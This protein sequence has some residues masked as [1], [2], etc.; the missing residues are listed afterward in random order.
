MVRILQPV[1]HLV[2]FFIFV[3]S[4]NA[5]Q[6]ASQAA[7]RQAVLVA[8]KATLIPPSRPCTKGGELCVPG[9]L[10]TEGD[11]NQDVTGTRAGRLG[12]CKKNKQ[13]KNNP[14]LI[15]A[16]DKKTIKIP[17]SV[18]CR[19]C[20]W[21]ESKQ[22]CMHGSEPC[23]KCERRY[24]H[25]TCKDKGSN[26]LEDGHGKVKIWHIEPQIG[27]GVVLDAAVLPFT[28]GSSPWSTIQ[29][30]SLS[31][32]VC[33][34]GWSYLSWKVQA[35]RHSKR[36]WQEDPPMAI[37]PTFVVPFGWAKTV[38]V[39]QHGGDCVETC[40]STRSDKL[41]HDLFAN[42]VTPK[43]QSQKAVGTHLQLCQVYEV[44]HDK[45]IHEDSTFEFPS[46]GHRCSNFWRSPIDSAPRSL[47]DW[48]RSYGQ[49]VLE[50][51]EV[52]INFIWMGRGTE[53]AKATKTKSLD[54][55]TKQQANYMI[56]AFEGVKQMITK[57]TKDEK[58]FYFYEKGVQSMETELANSIYSRVTKVPV[59]THNAG[60][61]I[62][63]ALGVTSSAAKKAAS[64]LD[65]FIVDLYSLEKPPY[66]F[67]KDVIAPFVGFVNGGYYFDTNTLPIKAD[68]EPSKFHDALLENRR[69]WP[70][71]PLNPGQ[72][73]VNYPVS[74]VGPTEINMMYHP[75]GHE[76][77]LAIMEEFIALGVPDQNTPANELGEM[78]TDA[79]VTVQTKQFGIPISAMLWTPR[80]PASADGKKRCKT[81]N[82]ETGIEVFDAHHPI[83]IKCYGGTWRTAAAE[84]V[85]SK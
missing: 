54:I 76:M 82:S 64:K 17:H 79:M 45:S 28:V 46:L 35:K 60:T 62:L 16:S 65:P 80:F 44:N 74:G 32:K 7:F 6:T 69:P 38:E 59:N 49:K 68:L 58:I 63:N 11:G 23:A 14:R 13:Q 31:T 18:D 75:K 3:G 48:E 83:L 71:Y 77:T 43:E 5:V 39:Q 56:Q 40:L 67:V 55:A 26:T 50:T 9:F 12:K 72:T 53:P 4:T 81:L 47:S 22:M 21:T 15:S 78:V 8:D 19:E 27:N 24:S 36:L 73:L 66:A 33:V 51:T 85:A 70:M 2:V 20:T 10:C 42:G 29:P 61:S 52:N 37:M 30:S 84:A 25:T 57:A 41:A 1:W 34:C